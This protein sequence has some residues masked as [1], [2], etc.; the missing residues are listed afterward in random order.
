MIS[1]RESRGAEGDENV[2]TENNISI[3]GLLSG[4]QIWYDTG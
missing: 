2:K 3:L 1:M 4:G